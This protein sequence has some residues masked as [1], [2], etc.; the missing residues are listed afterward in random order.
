MNRQCM[1]FC[2]LIEAATGIMNEKPCSNDPNAQML[3]KFIYL[4]HQFEE[5]NF[6]DGTHKMIRWFIS[7][8]QKDNMIGNQLL[9]SL[10]NGAKIYIQNIL[11]SFQGIP[12]SFQMCCSCEMC[13]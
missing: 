12:S 13:T 5:D 3:E 11:Q 6:V 2:P 9:R 10:E 4:V 1:K 8:R 7:L